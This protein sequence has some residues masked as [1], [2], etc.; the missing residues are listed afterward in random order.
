MLPPIVTEPFNVTA[1]CVF[2]MR[3]LL[4]RIGVVEF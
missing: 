1:D 2:E 3:F 4:R